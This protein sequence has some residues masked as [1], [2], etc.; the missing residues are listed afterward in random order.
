MIKKFSAFIACLILVSTVMVSTV[1]AQKS[2]GGTDLKRVSGQLNLVTFMQ[3]DDYSC[4][5]VNESEEVVFAGI[6][7]DN[8][9]RVN[10]EPPTT[11]QTFTYNNN[12]N[13][14]RDLIGPTDFNNTITIRQNPTNRLVWSS[15][16]AISAVIVAAS[17]SAHG[18]IYSY[19]DGAFSDS[20]LQNTAGGNINS[21]LFCYYEPAN[22]TIIKRVETFNGGN[23]ST[24]SFPF[25]STN[26]PAPSD[27]SLVDN[28]AQPADRRTFLTYR[29]RKLSVNNV[30]TV[31]ESLV[32]GWTL[33][34][35]TC[36]E[37][38]HSELPPQIQFPTTTDLNNRRASIQLEEGEEVAC[39]FT[40][41]Q[42]TPSAGSASISGRI[43]SNEGR[44]IGGATLI[45]VNVGTG[46]HRFARSNNFGYYKFE[47]LEAGELFSV[48]VRH[49]RYAFTPDTAFFTLNEDFA[50]VDF[51]AEQQF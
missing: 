41:L 21:I 1:P 22:V 44:T 9:L 2:F 47:G 20:N 17:G 40:N 7:T 14:S 39:I 51:F 23:S 35:L 18:R 4:K 33:G 42:A 25:T 38:D 28:N 13:P 29:F 27:F 45:L 48:T 34:D 19:P 15:T 50:N 30:L 10:Y 31:T 11:A 3:W 24:A 6:T 37:I 12:L 26:F 49:K 32:N 43:L 16:K 8:E 5:A 36:E 46:S